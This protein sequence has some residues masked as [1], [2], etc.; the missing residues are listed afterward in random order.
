MN[1]MT[2]ISSF[3]PKVLQEI[4]NHIPEPIVW[5]SENDEVLGGLHANPRNF[6]TFFSHIQNP[7]DMISLIS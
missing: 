1:R 5:I 2:G 4:I 7:T 6:R 3:N